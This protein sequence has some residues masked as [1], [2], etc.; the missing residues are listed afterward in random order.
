M[1][2]G[3]KGTDLIL[4]FFFPL[5]IMMNDRAFLVLNYMKTFGFGSSE[6]QASVRNIKFKL[7]VLI[8]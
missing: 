4:L 8:A 2:L 3:L 1:Q 7:D 5:Q 6:Q